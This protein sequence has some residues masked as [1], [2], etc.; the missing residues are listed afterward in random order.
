L[1]SD[2][3][4]NPDAAIDLARSL[5]MAHACGIPHIAVFADACRTPPSGR[6]KNIVGQSLFETIE[7]ALE[8]APEIDRF[9]ATRSGDASWELQPTGDDERLPAYGVYTRCLIAA[10]SGD[11][12]TALK[13]VE[14]GRE[15]FAV[16]SRKLD[17]HLREAVPEAV[18]HKVNRDTRERRA[19]A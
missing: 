15:Q 12:E 14:G 9:Y 5:R 11:E 1:L 17:G 3:M 19:F 16:V 8:P 2:A 7:P 10:L 13:K 6:L 4:S 18:S